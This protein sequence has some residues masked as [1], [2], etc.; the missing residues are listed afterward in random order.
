ML[1]F[2]VDLNWVIDIVI[3]VLVW[4]LLVMLG[5]FWLNNSRYFCGNVVCFRCVVFGML[6]I[7][8]MVKLVF[9]VNFSSLVVLLWWYNC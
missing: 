7:V 4:V 3:V 1:M 6:F 9:V 8:I 5:F 2:C